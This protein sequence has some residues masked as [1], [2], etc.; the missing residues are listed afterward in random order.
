MTG[1]LPREFSGIGDDRLCRF[2]CILKMENSFYNLLL[3]PQD[4]LLEVLARLQL[5]LNYTNLI[6]DPKQHYLSQWFCR[7]FVSQKKA[8]KEDHTFKIV[9]AGDPYVGKT[10]A[11]LRLAGEK[12]PLYLEVDYV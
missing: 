7:I 3:L 1:K 6:P 2:F 8:D 11:I 9:I 10:S 12:Q 5:V 4:I